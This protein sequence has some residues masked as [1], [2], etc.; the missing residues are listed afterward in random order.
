M[1]KMLYVVH[2]KV[3]KDQ[4]LAEDGGEDGGGDDQDNGADDDQGI[5]EIDPEGDLISKRTLAVKSAS[6]SKSAFGQS[7]NGSQGGSQRVMDWI[8]LFQNEEES[9]QMEKNELAQYSCTKL[10]R[11]MKAALDS[12]SDMGEMEG[13]KSNSVDD[14]LV[15]LPASLIENAREVDANLQL[16]DNL[17]NLLELKEKD[18]DGDS[19]EETK[20]QG[21]NQTKQTKKTWGPV[22]VEDR[23]RR[24]PFDGRSMLERAQE[25]KRV[26]NL[27]S[28]KGNCRSYNSFSV[29]APEEVSGIAKITCIKLGS[30]PA[31]VNVVVDEIVLD[32]SVRGNKFDE[33]CLVC[34]AVKE[35]SQP[36]DGVDEGVGEMSPSTPIDQILQPQVEDPGE[37][38][39]QWTRIV[40]R[41][42]SKP[43]VSK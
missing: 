28:L 21:G 34:H 2:F 41:K 36:S 4:G 26:A 42:R 23:P 14:E 19:V 11:E 9:A 18:V 30:T 43:K 27:E 32:S 17:Y 1:Q 15:S 20:S 38:Q 37:L 8:S 7:G 40:H 12:D 35:V 6:S 22:L 16:P 31:E 3:E 10:L 24:R 29:L 25:R 33:N 13:F 5:E 39:G